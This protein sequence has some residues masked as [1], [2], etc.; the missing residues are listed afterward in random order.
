MIAS[1]IF[2]SA[3]AAYSRNHYR[4]AFK[5]FEQ[6]ALA[7]D[8]ECM[9]HVA[10]MYTCGEGVKCDYDKAI[11][12]ELRASELGSRSALTNL[13][14]TYRMKGDLRNSK[15]YLEMA[16]NGGDSEA[17]LELAKLLVVSDFERDK[18]V[19]Y[20]DVVLTADN[21]SEY[22]RDEAIKLKREIS[23]ISD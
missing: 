20:L 8:V 15:R 2:E 19:E 9:I 18:I 7:G 10:S 16:L 5:L 4:K 23:A 6:G 3:Y 11:E 1:S 21:I 17:A 14:I 12:W 22:S 13:A